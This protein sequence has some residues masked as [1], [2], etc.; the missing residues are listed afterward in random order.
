MPVWA[1]LTQLAQIIFKLTREMKTE[2]DLF[3]K[4]MRLQKAKE[5]AFTQRSG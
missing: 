5:I 1:P 2:G 3:Y 4:T